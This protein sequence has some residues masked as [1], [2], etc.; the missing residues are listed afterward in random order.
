MA[1]TPQE[2]SAEEF[3]VTARLIA[4]DVLLAN[5]LGLNIREAIAAAVKGTYGA[6]Y[7]RG[8]REG[9]DAGFGA[10][11]TAGSTTGPTP[12]L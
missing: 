6:A 8:V 4:E 12:G 11:V 1:Q 5:A 7:E 9:Y 2:K 10:A 3:E